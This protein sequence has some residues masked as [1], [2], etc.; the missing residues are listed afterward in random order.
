[1]LTT[2]FAKRINTSVHIF[3]KNGKLKGIFPNTGYR[4]TK[5]T[6]EITLNCWRW[7]LEWIN[8]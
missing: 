5:A 6:K 1:M 7:K 2:L 8:N 3:D 4:P